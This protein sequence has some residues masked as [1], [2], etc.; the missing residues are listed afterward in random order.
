MPIA[1]DPT[2]VIEYVLLCDRD[3]PPEEQT[4]FELKVLTARELAKIEDGSARAD[5]S[6]NI[7]FRSGT[8]VI[9]IL[10]VGLKGWR[11]FKDA[12]GREVPFRENNGA[13]RPENWDYLTPDWRRELANAVTEQTRVTETER[14][15]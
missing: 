7:E 8:Q 6:G 12:Q 13:P 15:N 3:L 4:M 5:V 11:N 9:N 10:N 2:K 14:K 1:I